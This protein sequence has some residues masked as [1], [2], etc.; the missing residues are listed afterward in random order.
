MPREESE[1]VQQARHLDEVEHSPS[2]EA[3]LYGIAVTMRAYADK[4]TE[5]QAKGA[6]FDHAELAVALRRLQ[7]LIDTLEAA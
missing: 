1:R 5:L 3:T 4:V 2:A 7:D 6:E